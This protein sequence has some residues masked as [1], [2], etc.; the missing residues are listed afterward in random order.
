MGPGPFWTGAENLSPTGI[1]SPD[2][3]VCSELLYQLSY[4]GSSLRCKYTEIFAVML[5]RECNTHTRLCKY[6]QVI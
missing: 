3:P 6:T 4:P 5:F 1:R 2:R